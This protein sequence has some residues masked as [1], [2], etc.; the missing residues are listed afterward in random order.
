MGALRAQTTTWI[1]FKRD[2]ELVELAFNSRMMYIYNLSD[3]DEIPIHKRQFPSIEPY[4]RVQ[5][6]SITRLVGEKGGIN[7]S[8]ERR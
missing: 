3:I 1:R 6:P 7:K 5:L 2:D 8:K 4:K